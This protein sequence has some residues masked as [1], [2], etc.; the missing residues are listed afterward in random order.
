MA[1]AT[2]GA[3]LGLLGGIL[4]Y[5]RENI[6]DRDALASRAETALSNQ[7]VRLALAQPISD[8]IIDSGPAKLVNARPVI[9]SVVTGALGT[10]PVRAAVGEAVKALGEKLFDRDPQALLLNVA[11][12]A[13]LAAGTLEAVDPQ[14]AR[15]LP[16]RLRG[17]R[18]EIT[19][20]STPID[21]LRLA[22]KVSLG[23][24]LLPPLAVL[25]MVGSIAVAENRRRALVRGS[26]GLALAAIAGLAMLSVGKALLVSQFGDDLVADAVSV[27]WD[28]LLGDL[29]GAFVLAAVLSIVLAA[30]A[31]FSESAGFDPLAPAIR[32]GE[33][34][35]RRPRS[36]VLGGLRALCLAGGGLALV[37][38]PELA[39]ET[40]AL[41][42][43]AW[44]LYV[45]IGELLAI[46]APAGPKTPSTTAPAKRHLRPGRLIALA[47]LAAAV[48]F[49]VLVLPGGESVKQ[50]PS[51]PP[52]A[53][54][55]FAELC[56]KRL[57]EVTLAATH[58]SMSA[59]EEPGWFLPNQR[60]GIT[61]QLDDGIRALLIDTHYGIPRGDGRGFGQVITDLEKEQKTRQEVV[62]EIGE[63]GVRKAEELVGNLAFHGAASAPKP[64][65]CHVLCELGATP[66]PSALE[67][68]DTWMQA[69]PDEFLVIFIEDVVSPAETAAAF[70]RSGLLRYVYIP[71]DSV[72]P[73]TLGELIEDDDRLL[74]MAENDAGG[75]A[76]P[77]YQQGF[78]LFQ[79]T[80]FTFHSANEIESAE[81][82][83][84]NRGSLSNPLFQ[85]NSWIETI[86]RDPDLAGRID[87]R[88]ALLQR[89]RLCTRLRGL[90]PNLIAVD[91]YDHG[92]VLGVA[93]RLNGL[94]VP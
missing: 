79:E 70:E 29:R 47:G 93:D 17:V 24:L 88:E 36:P 90:K 55:G 59:A 23:G 37:L 15:R 2:L 16:D 41:I 91:F 69:H 56:G 44:A 22:D 1:L 46:L 12:G 52:Q 13:S 35:R 71:D 32:A 6:L 82:C 73:P 39:I 65:L 87:S 77:W 21:T 20:S 25:T 64:Y 38:R 54:N 84:P 10:S 42:A 78:D 81:S 61:R 30:A 33:L 57:D 51:G 49:V 60:Y 40:V 63:V 62:A 89:A 18:I 53:C 43:G 74:V 28:A 92:D 34:L 31:R 50:R 5:A 67:G 11:S 72:P 75:G 7:R 8:A 19:S 94:A 27:T 9:E 76:Y 86:P 66:L 45:A 58:N 26:V 80:P 3:L 85:I 4:L 83:R 14:L 68:I 48:L